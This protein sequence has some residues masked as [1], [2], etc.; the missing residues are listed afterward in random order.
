MIGK[1]VSHY[2][3]LEKLGEGGMGVVYKAEDTKLKRTVALKFLPPHLTTKETDKARFLQEAQTAAALNHNNIC[4]IYEIHDEGESPFIAMEYVEGKTLKDI[5]GATGRSPLQ[6]QDIIQYTIQIAEALKA[7]HAKGIIHRD[8]KSENIMVTE[9]GQVKVMDFGLARMRGSV[10]LTKSGS[11]KGTAAYMS[12]EQFQKADVDHRTDI[13]SFGVVLYEM[14]TD[15]LPFEGEYEAAV[16]YSVLNEKP[17]LQFKDSIP[18]NIRNVVEKALEKKPDDRWQTVQDILRDLMQPGVELTKTEKSIIVLPFDDMSPRKDN[19]YFSDGLTEEIITDLSHIHDLVVISRSSAMTFKGTKKKIREIARE[20]N[21]QYVLEGSVRKA[22]NNLR[23]TAQLIDAKTDAHLW[24]DKYSG[25]LDDVFDIQEKVSRRIVDALKLELSSKEIN[26]LSERPIEN[27][28]SFEFYLRAKQEIYKFTEQSLNRAIDYLKKALSIE[29][30]NELLYAELAHAYYQF[31]NFGIRIEEQ[32]LK[33]ANI[34]VQ[35]VFA[36]N[37]DSPHGHFVCGLLETTGGNTI[38]AISHFQKVLSKAPNHG[39]ALAWLATAY[40]FLG[41][42]KKAKQTLGRLSMIDPFHTFVII[43]PIT[44]D[45]YS[46]KFESA[47]EKTE[48]LLKSNP[49][50]MSLLNHALSLIYYGRFEKAFSIYNNFSASYQRT[51]LFRVF[52][53]FQ[54]AYQKNKKEFEKLIDAEFK[55]WA[56]KDFS[57]SFWVAEAYAL[58]DDREKALDWLENAVNRGF[59]NYPFLSNYDPFLE[60]I[61]GEERFKKLMKQVKKEWE[62]FET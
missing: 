44:Y 37:K 42:T 32:D 41:I 35:K 50:D 13:W 15:R 17:C 20:V 34:Y 39:D 28:R 14:L 9:T 6:M 25:T 51:L 60:N 10:K 48:E 38:T 26:K 27:A 21:V 59:I 24:A 49:D 53:L 55:L 2:K 31:W 1:T 46:G 57:Y 47:V 52:L 58:I 33:Q 7:A 56:E 12:P 40:T 4:T 54:F 3:I 11:T 30:E 22:G 29:G 8:I 16:M 23:I 45:I 18:E 43:L 36:L 62:S 19:E 61:R 5:V